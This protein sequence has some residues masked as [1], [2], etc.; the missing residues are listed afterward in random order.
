MM[1]RMR[2]DTALVARGLVESLAK[3]RAVV[4][5]GLVFSGE[6][7]LDKAGSMIAEHQPL[8]A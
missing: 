8:A 2:L 3:A 6:T 7:R 4:L 1:A 5:A